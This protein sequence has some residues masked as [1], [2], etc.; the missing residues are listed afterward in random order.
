MVLFYEAKRESAT[1]F[2]FKWDKKNNLNYNKFF[3]GWKI[4]GLKRPQ[5]N[6]KSNRSGTKVN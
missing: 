1:D 5:M 6:T 3:T 2:Y 4:H